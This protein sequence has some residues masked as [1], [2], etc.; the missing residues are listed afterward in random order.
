MSKP[1]RKAE[2]ELLPDGTYEVTL[3]QWKLESRATSW[4]ERRAENHARLPEA[5]ASISRWF[6]GVE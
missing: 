2:I 6:K 4:D 5:Q 1:R 3:V